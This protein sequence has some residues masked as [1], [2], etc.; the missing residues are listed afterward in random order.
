MGVTSMVVELFVA[1]G[2]PAA[3]V[4]GVFQPTVSPMDS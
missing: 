3:A 1:A 2:V 4:T